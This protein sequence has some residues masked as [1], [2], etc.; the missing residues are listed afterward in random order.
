[1]YSKN[2]GGISTVCIVAVCLLYSL[3]TLRA[4]SAD[5]RFGCGLSLTDRGSY[6]QG[7]Y[8]VSS[9]LSVGVSVGVVRWSLRDESYSSTIEPYARFFFSTSSP[10]K[11][12][13]ATSYNISSTNYA[14]MSGGG[15]Y[16]LSDRFAVFGQVGLLSLRLYKEAERNYISGDCLGTLGLA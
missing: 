14:E 9:A 1:M 16:F 7:S 2:L 3:Q 6:I 11:P 13:L 12:Y 5:N 8:A 4:Q 15:A 10:L